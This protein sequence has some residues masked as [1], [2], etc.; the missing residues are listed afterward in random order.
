MALKLLTA[1]KCAI[2]SMMC[3]GSVVDAVGTFRIVTSIN[4]LKMYYLQY[5]VLRLCCG[6]YEY[7]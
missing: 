6:G 1:L 4:G 7:V 5:D 2:Y 3:Q